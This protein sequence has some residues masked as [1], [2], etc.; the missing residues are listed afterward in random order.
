[1]H[2]QVTGYKTTLTSLVCSLG[3]QD[4][5]NFNA[6]AW[7]ASFKVLKYQSFVLVVAYN[8]TAM[9]V[10]EEQGIGTTPALIVVFGKR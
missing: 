6:L 2:T 8:E 9:I 10:G 3:R 5:C 1:M 4:I 7:C